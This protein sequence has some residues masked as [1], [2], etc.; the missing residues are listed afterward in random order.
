VASQAIIVG[1]NVSADA[2]AEHQAEAD[3]VQIRTYNIIYRLI[4]DL[5]LALEGMLKPVYV[6]KVQGHAVVRQVFNISKV[7]Q[8][9][10]SQVTDGKALRNAKARIY[11]EGKLLCE[12]NVS[13]LKRF[14]EDVREVATGLEC[15][16]GVE[17]AKGIQV[18]DTIEFYT[19]E[20]K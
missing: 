1:F 3:G 18:G 20:A 19:M 14:T 10:G 17:G 11:H 7:G 4:E 8:I 2:A 6:E 9:A 5:Q 15:G 12:G 13:S 16:I